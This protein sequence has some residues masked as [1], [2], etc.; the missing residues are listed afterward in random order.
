MRVRHDESLSLRITTGSKAAEDAPITKVED[1]R[2]APGGD[3][4]HSR[5]GHLTGFHDALITDYD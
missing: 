4:L 1:L 3:E 5:R 2:G